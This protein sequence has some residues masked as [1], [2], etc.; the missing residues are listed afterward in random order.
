MLLS[1]WELIADA[2][3]RIRLLTHSLEHAGEGFR[4]AAEERDSWRLKY[5][6]LL[7]RSTETRP[8]DS[9]VLKDAVRVATNAM[10][11]ATLAFAEKLK[12]G[13]EA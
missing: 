3:E 11:D 8:R 1:E 4:L 13:S 2:T 9:L 10:A 12:H 6:D 7:A 5:N